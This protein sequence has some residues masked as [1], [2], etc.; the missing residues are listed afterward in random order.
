MTLPTNIILPF[1]TEDLNGND[2][3]DIQAY[4]KELNDSLQRMYEDI[5]FAVNGTI[6]SNYAIGRQ[7]WRP[8]LKGTTADG[9]FTYVNRAGWAL[10][11]GLMV[12]AWG[13]I[14]WTGVGGATGNL[15]VELPY[16]V[17]LSDNTPFVGVVQPS[18]FAYTGGSGM[19]INGISNT[20][21]GEFW[22][23]GTGFTTARQA[24]VASGRVIFHIRYIGQQN[25][26]A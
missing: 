11:Q 2:P 15:F 13:D 10:R 17:A 3:K 5:S 20:F 8:V 18:A 7:N 26:T 6:R 25:E 19:V 21:R 16:K 14:S 24:V 9:S 12:D 4:L 22:N 1:N 23:T